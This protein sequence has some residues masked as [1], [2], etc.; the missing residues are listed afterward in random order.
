MDITVKFDQDT[1]V[2]K[3]YGMPVL[4]ANTADAQ[5]LFPAR[6][7]AAVADTGVSIDCSEM[8]I[9]KMMGIGR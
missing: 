1:S 7:T 3:D 2:R 9:L 8:E 6:N 4:D 5:T